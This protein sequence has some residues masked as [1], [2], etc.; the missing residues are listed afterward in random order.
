MQKKI[1]L[2]LTI[3]LLVSISCKKKPFETEEIYSYVP[4]QIKHPVSF[5]GFF[6]EDIIYSVGASGEVFVSRE[7]GDNW[8]QASSVTACLFGL[9]IISSETA[10]AAGHGADICFTNDGGKTWQ[11]PDNSEAV[12]LGYLPYLSF[13]DEMIGWVA[14]HDLLF[15]TSDGGKNWK[16]LNLPQEDLKISAVFLRTSE[17][18]YIL[19]DFKGC[20][21]VTNNNGKSW[22]TVEIGANA[23]KSNTLPSPTAVVRFKNNK[24][25]VIIMDDF[26]PDKGWI[27]LKTSDGGN[28]W[29]KSILDLDKGFLYISRDN[30][31]ITITDLFGKIKAYTVEGLL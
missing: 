28:S 9:D 25:G 20:L 22:D 13:I 18:G 14:S 1:I 19:D 29:S 24:E 15:S 12:T 30:K 8:F 23:S 11:K 6:D 4:D 2:F 5:A 10:W 7:K 16:E 27:V 26:T 3:I 17:E 21:Y 31:I